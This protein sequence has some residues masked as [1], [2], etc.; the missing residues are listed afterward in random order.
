MDA[1]ASIKPLDGEPARKKL[2]TSELPLS[3]ATRAA[4]QGLTHTFKKKGDYDSIRKQ[5]L[6]SLETEVS[7]LSLGG[8]RVI[9]RMLI[10][11]I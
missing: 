10:P 4:V 2:K 11:M 3:S 1:L 8:N 7:I 9:T 6:Q 5:V